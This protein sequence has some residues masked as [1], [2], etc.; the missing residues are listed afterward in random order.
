M[1]KYM[2]AHRLPE[3]ARA[4][5]RDGLELVMPAVLDALLTLGAD[6]QASRKAIDAD[7]ACRGSDTSC[8][9]A[10]GGA[11]CPW[12]PCNQI[13][14]NIAGTPLPGIFAR[15]YEA[16]RAASA[17]GG[18]CPLL[19]TRTLERRLKPDPP[20]AGALRSFAGVF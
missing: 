1:Q 6:A 8:Q 15:Q 10:A 20:T 12:R 2:L 7:P 19:P 3:V 16:G 18:V 5:G 11:V 14:C 9:R 4:S 13:C 17:W